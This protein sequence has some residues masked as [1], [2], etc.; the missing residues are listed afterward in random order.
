M[1]SEGV[2]LSGD[3]SSRVS[4][5]WRWMGAQAQGEAPTSRRR[6]RSRATRPAR[7]GSV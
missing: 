1:S 3:R 4:L 6:E 5:A 7:C 2:I